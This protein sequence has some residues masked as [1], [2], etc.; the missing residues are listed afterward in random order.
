MEAY[1]NI[2]TGRELP[3]E[4]YFTPTEKEESEEGDRQEPLQLDHCDL[5][6]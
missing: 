3:T 6:F 5:S 2:Q 4:V 1:R